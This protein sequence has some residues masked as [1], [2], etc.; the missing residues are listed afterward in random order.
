MLVILLFIFGLSTRIIVHEPNFTP[1]TALALFGGVYLSKKWAVILPLSLMIISDFFIGMHDTIIFTWG[2]FVL[3]AVIGLW[4]RNHKN[5]ITILGSSAVSAIL[6]FVVTNFGVWLIGRYPHTSYPHTIEGLSVC[7][8]AAL[9]FFRNT[10]LSSLLYSAVL[11]GSYEFIASR[12][13]E[14]RFARVLLKT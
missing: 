7:F 13:K 10:F 6:F 9:P 11:F 12:V 1:I 14:T 2:S 4:V 5:L 3:I 8:T